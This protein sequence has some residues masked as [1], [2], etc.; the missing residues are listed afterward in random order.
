MSSLEFLLIHAFSVLLGGFTVIRRVSQVGITL[1][2]VELIM[3]TVLFASFIG[4][5]FI[6]PD[7]YQAIPP[8]LTI[9]ALPILFSEKTTELIRSKILNQS[10][11][12]ERRPTESR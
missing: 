2:L 7:K 6:T 3:T 1:T 11:K 10:R 4:L 8:I 5:V 12:H 9:L